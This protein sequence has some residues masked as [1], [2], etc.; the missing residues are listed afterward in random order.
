MQTVSSR[1]PLVKPPAALFHAWPYI[2]IWHP[3]V[4]IESK[5]CLERA[6]AAIAIA[7]PPTYSSHGLRCNYRVSQHR[8]TCLQ[9]SGHPSA[10]SCGAMVGFFIELNVIF[11]L[12]TAGLR[13][14]LYGQNKKTIAGKICTDTCHLVQNNLHA[15]K[16]T[17]KFVCCR[18]CCDARTT[19]L[20]NNYRIK[21][22]RKK[23]DPKWHKHFCLLPFR[24]FRAGLKTKFPV[25][26]I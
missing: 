11:H 7:A 8:N 5:S 3:N 21:F 16:L 6:K 18:N 19:I 23:C 14:L 17:N 2:I 10:S 12:K 13:D 1:K 4:C 24:A 9:N 20:G 25:R 22:L 26:V 15:V